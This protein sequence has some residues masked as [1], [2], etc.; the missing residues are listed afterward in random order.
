VLRN[1]VSLSKNL[2]DLL[3]APVPP[4]LLCFVVI[5]HGQRSSLH[6]CKYLPLLLYA[7]LTFNIYSWNPFINVARNFVGDGVDFFCHV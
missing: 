5:P 1:F 7:M 3:T 4:F 2:L 6:Y